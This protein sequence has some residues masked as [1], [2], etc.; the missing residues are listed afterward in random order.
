MIA[1]GLMACLGATASAQAPQ[2][3]AGLQERPIRALSEQQIADLKAGRGIGLALAA[4]LNGYPQGYQTDMPAFEKR[5]SDE[6][7][8]S[9][10]AFIKSTWQPE[11]RAKQ[12][13]MNAETRRD[14]R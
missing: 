10:L 6:E 3:Y 5:L 1:V 7:I 2:H 14:Q 8:A 11:I 4:E 13:R 9:V 12:A